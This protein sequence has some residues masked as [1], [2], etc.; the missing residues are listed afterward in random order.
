M[1]HLI[2]IADLVRMA[3][4]GCAGSLT[5]LLLLALS[6]NTFLSRRAAQALW[7]HF[8]I[9]TERDHAAAPTPEDVC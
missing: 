5:A 2:P 8:K 1:H 6:D 9:K 4:A 3:A 7:D